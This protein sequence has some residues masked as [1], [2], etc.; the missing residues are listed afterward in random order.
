MHPQPPSSD[1]E[2]ARNTEKRLRALE[3]APHSL[4]IGQWVLS[5]TGGQL[6]ATSSDGQSYTLSSA[7]V[8]TSTPVTVNTPVA[9]TAFTRV[10]TVTL[11]GAP[12]GGTFTLTVSGET[13]SGIAYNASASDVLAALAAL[14]NYAA[15]DFSVSGNDGGPWTVGIPGISIS[16]DNSGLTYGIIHGTVQIT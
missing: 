4:R 16:G 10:V 2:W 3:S 6:I 8:A 11:T 5:D 1:A 7:V 15:T 9:G 14:P 12:Q 13:T